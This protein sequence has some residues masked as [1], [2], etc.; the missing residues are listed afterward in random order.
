[1]CGGGMGG[2]SLGVIN[3]VPPEGKISVSVDISLGTALIG[4]ISK[5]PPDGGGG[6]HTVWEVDEGIICRLGPLHI[7]FI[8]CEWFWPCRHN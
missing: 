5:V 4:A 6:M 2:G 8:K 1:M 3:N 7:Q